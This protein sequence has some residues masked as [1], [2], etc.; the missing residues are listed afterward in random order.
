MLLDRHDWAGAFDD[1]DT[2][3][4]R[5]SSSSDDTNYVGSMSTSTSSFMSTSYE[6]GLGLKLGG[7]D[8]PLG[9][10]GS[11]GLASPLLSSNTKAG[12]RKVQV[13]VR[14]EESEQV[15]ASTAEA[16]SFDFKVPVPG[17]TDPEESRTSSITV[18]VRKPPPE[19]EEGS[20]TT[21]P[22][23]SVG[24]S[25]CSS[26][27]EG[28]RKIVMEISNGAQSGSSDMFGLDGLVGLDLGDVGRWE[29]V[30]A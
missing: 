3:D 4:D 24:E 18:H 28:G 8:V 19:E 12:A 6:G 27:T 9:G 17:S 25:A 21:S 7:M 14:R 22:T 30:V 20:R 10:F 16:F 26:S 1:L 11:L 5:L 23:P 15:P 13:S 2:F 29:V